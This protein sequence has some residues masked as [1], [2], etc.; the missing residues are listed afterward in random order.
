ML[1]VENY[2]AGV[3]GG[4]IPI[5]AQALTLVE[6]RNRQHQVLAEELLSQ[7]MPYTGGAIR[8][9]ITG[10]PGAGKSTFIEALGLLLIS[11]GHRVAVL[12]IDPSSAITGGSILGDKTRMPKLAA[13]PNAY[14]R[15]SP[16]SGTWGGAAS[17]TRECML[18][19]E[20][21]GYDVVL[22]ETVGVGQSESTVARMTDCLL[23]VMLPLAGDELQ[24]IKRGLLEWIDLLVVNKADGEMRSACEVAAGQ[25]RTALESLAARTARQPP[26]VLTCS[27][28]E[29]KGIEAVWSAVE[30]HHSQ[31][32]ANGT[33]ESHR[34][35]Q[36]LHWFWAA[37]E[38]R[39][40]QLIETHPQVKAVRAE[41]EQQVLAGD[42][43][44][45]SVAQKILDAGGLG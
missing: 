40:R 30:S 34:Q 45:E 39:L 44:V 33:L 9:G 37:V 1:S 19:C 28:L 31:R 41:C 12:A 14:I 20:A 32:K 24:G 5:L 25:Y 43:S 29:N 11:Q 8:V 3:R 23:A 7:L 2:F 35:D 13:E 4:E 36:H 10:P 18:I 27:A 17:T 38:D 16:A 26:K 21:A 6:S 15:P 22:I 42:V